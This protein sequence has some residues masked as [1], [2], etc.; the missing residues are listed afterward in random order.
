MH[1]NWNLILNRPSTA[2]LRTFASISH[3]K[4]LVNKAR[5]NNKGLGSTDTMRF[6]TAGSDTDIISSNQID[7]LLR[8]EQ[9][10]VVL[11]NSFLTRCDVSHVGSNRPSEDRWFATKLACH[12]EGFLFGVL[13][14]HG[15]EICAESICQRLPSYM[16]EFLLP[17]DNFSN[18][19]KSRCIDLFNKPVVSAA[20]DF[21]NDWLCQESFKKFVIGKKNRS[22]EH[23]GFQELDSDVPVI[24]KALG[25][26]F[27]QMDGDLLSE[28]L[29]SV[30]DDRIDD[31]V[32][33]LTA[34]QSGSC[35]LACYVTERHLFIA[36]AGDCR[37]V[38]GIKRQDGTVAPRPL[39]LDQTA[40][41][42]R[43]S[44][45]CGPI[46]TVTMGQS[47][48]G[49]KRLCE[50]KEICILSFYKQKYRRCLNVAGIQS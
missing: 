27:L 41:S 49:T 16:A 11:K 5:C 21:Y 43:Q 33:Y 6:Y 15:G 7:I 42:E 50:L 22:E 3:I 48:T 25:E 23:V 32:P 40:G 18:S 47:G 2:Q 35:A 37:A 36:N 10:S 17:E 20:H 31:I 1:F 8:R 4:L 39:S 29:I 9:H 46:C 19:S 44:F 14:G 28:A 38:A 45:C 24:S 34:A 12:E 26:A 13:D 30:E